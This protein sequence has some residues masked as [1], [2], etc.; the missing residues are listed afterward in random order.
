[1][2]NTDEGINYGHQMLQVT[3]WR[4]QPDKGESS[5][6]SRNDIVRKLKWRMAKG[7]SAVGNAKAV[8]WVNIES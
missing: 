8:R 6:S 1:M 2:Y 7:V 3:A 4:A 5:S